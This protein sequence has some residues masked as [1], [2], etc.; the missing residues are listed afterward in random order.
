MTIP[1]AEEPSFDGKF[2]P[3]QLATVRIEMSGTDAPPCRLQQLFILEY[4]KEL[5]DLVTTP[6][7]FD[8]MGRRKEEGERNGVRGLMEFMVPMDLSLYSITFS[9]ARPMLSWSLSIYLYLLHLKSLICSPITIC[10]DGIHMRGH[11]RLS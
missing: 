11:F 6:Y 1:P 2:L 4:D 3:L 5:G 9:A 10:S 8:D 7:L